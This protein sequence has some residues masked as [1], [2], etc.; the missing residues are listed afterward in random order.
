MLTKTK[1]N[2]DGTYNVFLCDERDNYLMVTLRNFRTLDNAIKFERMI[3]ERL[4]A[5]PRFSLEWAHV[6][7]MAVTWGLV[8][9]GVGSW[10][11]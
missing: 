11:F 4:I 1:T 6:V 10:I 3:N 2:R 5:R 7:G 8:G 9:L